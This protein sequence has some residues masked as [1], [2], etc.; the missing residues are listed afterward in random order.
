MPSPFAERF[1]DALRRSEKDHTPD[2]LVELF[3]EKAELRNLS[4]DAPETGIAGARKFWT[5]YLDSFGRIASTFH[6]VVEGPDGIVL[7]WTSEGTLPDGRP[8]HYRGVSV[9]E[10]AND[11]V[12][13]FRA[14][15]DS[16]A[17]VKPTADTAAV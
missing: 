17:F 12:R 5:A 6:H 2:P 11:R 8:I 15:Y 14:Y 4:G 1:M 7:E 16:A 9:L 13:R 3:D 10:A